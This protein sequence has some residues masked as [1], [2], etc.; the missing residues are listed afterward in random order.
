[1]VESNDPRS[2]SAA[3]RA[4]MSAIANE[5]ARRTTPAHLK[6]ATKTMV[7][8]AK[9]NLK[10]KAIEQRA[11]ISSNARRHPIAWGAAV[12]V[13]AGLLAGMVA[14]GR[15]SR[16]HSKSASHRHRRFPLS[17]ALRPMRLPDAGVHFS[18]ADGH[19]VSSGADF[20]KELKA[21]GKAARGRTRR[22]LRAG[23]R[24]PLMLAA[25]ALGLGLVV[26]RVLPRTSAERAELRKLRH[27]MSEALGSLRN[28]LESRLD[29][30]RQASN[31]TFVPTTDHLRSP[32][33]RAAQQNE[34]S[35]SLH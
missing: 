22:V 31:D 17:E 33:E 30:N 32:E 1:M 10:D 29:G 35:P 13:S 15:A 6:E 12:G 27:R 28:Q 24:R 21:A 34:S 4:R 3:A 16:R 14:R 20:R 2:E 18:I 9:D 23:G 19:D 5:L 11:K 8:D 26:A 7:V 25:A